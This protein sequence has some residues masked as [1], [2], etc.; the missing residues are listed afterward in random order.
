MSNQALLLEEQQ[1]TI[2]GC[3]MNVFIEEKWRP[4]LKSLL[5]QYTL[6]VTALTA[7]YKTVLRDANIVM[8]EGR[9]MLGEEIGLIDT[10]TAA[11]ERLLSLKVQ[12]MYGMYTY[13]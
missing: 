6:L 12:C 10:F 4:F 9:V 5:H 2:M 13:M 11:K 7:V 3:E 8:E 1:S